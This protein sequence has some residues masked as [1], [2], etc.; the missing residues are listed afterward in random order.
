MLNIKLTNQIKKDIAR[1]IKEE[2]KGKDYA[3][4]GIFYNPN[5]KWFFIDSTQHIDKHKSEGKTLYK[6]IEY[7]KSDNTKM[8]L[9]EIE[10]M[11]FGNSNTIEINYSDPEENSKHINEDYKIDWFNNGEWSTITVKEAKNIFNESLSW[12]SIKYI[13]EI[14]HDR[15]EVCYVN[16]KIVYYQNVH[17]IYGFSTVIGN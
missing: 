16:G 6:I 10:R 11:V 5:T 14:G 12:G 7:Y 9:Q 15:I 8:S 2:I 1:D 4:I 17:G 3:E 13:K